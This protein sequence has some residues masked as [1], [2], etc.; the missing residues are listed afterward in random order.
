MGLSSLA[1]S[2]P[3]L[4]IESAVQ[5]AVV[6]ASLGSSTAGDSLTGE[7]GGEWAGIKSD[8][9]G[10][11]L[12][13]W[14][15]LAA[16]RT[17]ILVNQPQPVALLGGHLAAWGRIGL[18]TTITNPWSPYVGARLGGDLL[19][20]A[21]TGVSPSALNTVNN[22]DGVAGVVA[23]GVVGIE[24]GVSMLDPSRSLRIVVI[25]QE[26]L[27]AQQTYTPGFA[28][29]DLG[30]G[31]RFD[32]ADS[33]TTLLEVV[34]GAAPARTNPALGY[35]DQTFHG[36][37]EFGLRNIFA[38]G[39]WLG[40]ALVAERYADHITYTPG[41]SYTTGDAFTLGIEISFGFPLW[42]QPS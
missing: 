39:M 16:L 25:L 6:D 26:S 2:G 35:S 41:S 8:N 7:F 27:H 15:L 21:Q 14:D 18:R 17:G 1:L 32:V 13:D 33:L 30:L 23:T 28:F 19:L 29:T 9:P 42:R 3:A 11:W 22:A 34:V 12:V 40:V 24:L 31:A 37:V 4:A 10:R 20:V 38:N 36:R 5:G